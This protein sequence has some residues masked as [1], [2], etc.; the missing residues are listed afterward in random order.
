MS[1]YYGGIDVHV[2]FCQ[3]SIIDQEG[4]ELINIDVE[5][6][7]L[8]LIRFVKKLP[9]PIHLIVES[10]TLTEWVIRILEP[11]V[12]CIQACDPRQNKWISS[13]DKS[14]D[15]VDATRLANL[16]R[17]GLYNPVHIPLKDRQLFREM[18]IEYHK[19]TQ[20]TTRIKNR[21][22][23]KYRSRGIEASGQL[24]FSKRGREHYLSLLDDPLRQ[25]TTLMYFKVFDELIEQ[26]KKLLQNLRSRSAAYPE[27]A[28]FMTVPGV[29]FIVA[30]TFFAIVD[31]PWRFESKEKLWSYCRLG[32]NHKISA[33]KRKGGGQ[34]GGSRLL[35]SMLMRAA[36]AAIDSCKHPNEFSIHRSELLARG[37]DNRT[38]RRSAARKICSVLYGMFKN[39]QPYRSE[40]A[41]KI[42]G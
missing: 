16:L 28:N 10:S 23:A 29:G 12:D 36:G 15:K 40:A 1:K 33:G 2:K 9:K 25:Q 4:K 13:S 17:A 14:N 38:S 7:R 39:G 18:V 26:R 21:I 32:V 11:F 20:E 8:Q 42:S 35:K 27:I 22:K 37:K 24:V 34:K 41:G 5:T 30:I 3:F 19:M 31:T 6:N